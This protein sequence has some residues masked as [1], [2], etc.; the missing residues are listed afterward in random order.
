MP[1]APEILI[2]NATLPDGGR[3]DIRVRGKRIAEVGKNLQPGPGCEQLDAS[4][5]LAYPG[6]VN[7]HHHLFQSVLKA[8]PEGI[9]QP[10]GPWLAHVPYRAW[11]Q[12]TPELMYCAA[13]VGLSELLRSGCTTCADHHYLYHADTSPELEEAIFQAA[14]ELGMRLVLCRGGGSREGSHQGLA[15]TDLVPESIELRLQRM[16]DSAARHH[17]PA[18]DAMTRVVVAPTSV[19]HASTRQELLLL[20]EFARDQGLRRHSHLLEVGFDEEV[21][22]EKH[23]MSAIDYMDDVGWLGEDVWFAHLVHVDDS[24][25]SKLLATHTGIAHCPTSNA[26]LGSGVAR[27]PEMHAGGLPV[28]LGVDGSASAESGSMVSE[29]LLAWLVHRAVG[30]PA[31][32]QVEQVQQWASRGG[33]QVLGFPELGALEAGMLADIVLYD[34]A[35]PRFAGVWEP[36]WAP[37]VCGEPITAREVMINGE[38]R[39]RGGELLGVDQA[40][41]FRQTQRQLA[42]LVDACR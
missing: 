34:L 40:E 24:G 19:I 33:A 15:V 18:A 7:T 21:A 17:D 10:L 42:I 5:L 32:T 13:R 11:G 2:G 41:L 30:G 8:V 1:T 6:L 4:G 12:V 28:S 14:R 36:Q 3:A 35:A 39:V 9:D 20:A 16:Q 29:M 25:L 26:R 23:G 37:V 27:V 31:A 38:W 22:R